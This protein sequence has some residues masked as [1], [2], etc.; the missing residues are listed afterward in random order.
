MRERMRENERERENERM[1]ERGRMRE[2][3][4]G[5]EREMEGHL[6]HCCSLHS[7]LDHELDPKALSKG[8]AAT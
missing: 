3:E 1:R 8:K 6:N 4:E 2:R 5:G 7:C